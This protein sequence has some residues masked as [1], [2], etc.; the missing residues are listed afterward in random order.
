LAQAI[1]ARGSTAYSACSFIQYVSSA[2]AM[3][4]DR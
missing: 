4:I 1:L 3:G 2:M